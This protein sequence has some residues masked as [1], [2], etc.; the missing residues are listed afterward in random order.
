MRTDP[1]HVSERRPE[2]PKAIDAVVSKAL[3]KDPKK[4]YGSCGELVQSAR[5]ALGL[6][7]VRIVRARLPLLL[8]AGALVAS[9]AVAAAFALGGDDRSPLALRGNSLVRIDP[10]TNRVSA[11]IDVGDKPASVAVAGDTAWVYNLGDNT[12]SQI[13]TATNEVRRTTGVTTFPYTANYHVGP[14]LA[15]NS[16][17]AWLVGLRPDLTGV[18]TRIRLN[19]RKDEFELDHSALAVAA[20]ETAV[21]VLGSHNPEGGCPVAWTPPLAASLSDTLLRLSPSTG[22]VV[23]G[24]PVRDACGSING[25]AHDERW[26]WFFESGWSNLYRLD[27]RTSRITGVADLGPGGWGPGGAVPASGGGK[28]WVHAS[29]QGGRLVGVDS[30]TLRPSRTITSVPGRFGQVRYARGSLWW[31]DPREGTLLRFDPK[32]GK[33]LST[34]R[35]APEPGAERFSSSAIATGAGA[36]WVTVTPDFLD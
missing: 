19:G 36:V 21:W 9:V 28:V 5:Q 14:L 7:D 26:V 10:A 1:P 17:G 18:V 16:E 30:T 15:A 31:N 25:I 8:A 20:T 32:S 27:P 34:I 2:L 12:I 29:D 13:D 22:R 24:V 35:V 23:D 4:R 3:A 6:S 33:I 11:V